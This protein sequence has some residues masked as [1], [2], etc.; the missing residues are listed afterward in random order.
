MSCHGWSGISPLTPD[1]TLIGARSIN[2]L[3]GANV[4][5]AV[6]GGIDRPA[7]SLSMPAFRDAYSDAEVAAVANYVTAH[8]GI[9][10]SALLVTDVA[11]LR[12][13]SAP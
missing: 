11:R 1:A 2:D 10:A 13:Q 7:P 12:K 8:F 9:K 4:A 6:L 5:L 3:T